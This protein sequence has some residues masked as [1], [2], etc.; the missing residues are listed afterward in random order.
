MP[1]IENFDSESRFATFAITSL[2]TLRVATALA[3]ARR[4]S[5]GL[6]LWVSVFTAGI[7]PSC[8]DDGWREVG[9][10]RPP[11]TPKSRTPSYL[12]AVARRSWTPLDIG[13]SYV[14]GRRGP[15]A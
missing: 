10:D 6:A 14:A 13:S 15:V 5:S 1:R 2:G 3:R 8:L 11:R 4:T 7:L 12:A 9:A